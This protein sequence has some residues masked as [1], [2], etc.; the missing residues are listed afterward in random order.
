MHFRVAFGGARR[1]KVV[2]HDRLGEPLID[3]NVAAADQVQRSQ[4]IVRAARH[5]DI[6]VDGADADEFEVRV[7]RGQH[8]GHRVVG[9]GV[10]VDHEFTSHF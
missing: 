2:A 6:A 1:G 8:D 4:R 5:L 9:A 10:A 7:Q 3:R